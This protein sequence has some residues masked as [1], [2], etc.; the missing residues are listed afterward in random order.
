MSL[1]NFH[2][3]GQMRNVDQ[4]YCVSVKINLTYA[5]A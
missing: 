1:K 4:K 5:Y 2:I 3:Y